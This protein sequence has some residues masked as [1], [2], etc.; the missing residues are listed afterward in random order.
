MATKRLD[1]RK[2]K[3]ILRLKWEQGLIPSVA[4]PITMVK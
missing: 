2:T 3:E 1:M 4:G